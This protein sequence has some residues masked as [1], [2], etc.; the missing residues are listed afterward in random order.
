MIT[1]LIN[2]VK[3]AGYYSVIWDATSN[4]PVYT[5]S[6]YHQIDIRKHKKLC[7]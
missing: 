4:H 7:L 3:D 2:D 5:L 6:N 1:S